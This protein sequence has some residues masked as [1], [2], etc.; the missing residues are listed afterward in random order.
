M[1]RRLIQQLLRW[2]RQV[3][4]QIAGTKPRK[5]RQSNPNRLL[6]QQQPTPPPP[7]TAPPPSA[8]PP[9]TAIP[10]QEQPS[11]SP[12]VRPLTM[13]VSP[14]STVVSPTKHLNPA[15]PH[16][17]NGSNFQVFLSNYQ[18]PPS[19]AIQDLHQQLY[20]GESN[21]QTTPNPSPPEPPSKPEKTP[22]T[23]AVPPTKSFTVQPQTAESN[24]PQPSVQPFTLQD[25]PTAFHPVPPPTPHLETENKIQPTVAIPEITQL[26]QQNAHSSHQSL[27]QPLDTPTEDASL[28]NRE[29]PS[30]PV[31]QQSIQSADPGAITKQG[32][33]K[34]LF[35]LKKNN[36]HGYI[37]PNDGSKD[38]IF[39]QKY[40]GHDVF[41]QL[42]R[43][44]E[45][46]VTAHITEG[47][48]YA[49]QVR[50]L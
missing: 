23:P 7:A 5:K 48:A 24:P 50:I 41:H 13:D 1:V 27:V 32:V 31:V 49:D 16:A 43:G 22:Q 12:P 35:K 38:I 28:L 47:K 34:L 10:R 2:I 29:P 37:A 15:S 8:A 14:P 26:R 9:Q 20:H 39:H 21:R 45:V 4:S 40:I 46:E 30:M 42:E 17:N 3:I 11:L 25:N 33:V 36:H 18:R 44:M 6:Q 19:A